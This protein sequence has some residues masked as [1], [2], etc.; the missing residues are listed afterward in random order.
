MAVVKHIAVIRFSAMGDVAMTVPVIKNFL[1]QHPD[2]EITMVSSAFLQPLFTGMERCHFHP[3]FL[4]GGHTGVKGMYKLYRELKALRKFDAVADLHGVLRSMILS[5]FFKLS[6]YKTATIDKGRPGKK[7]LT[8]KENKVMKQLPT[9]FERYASVFKQ[10]G[11]NC[12]L[13]HES[14]VYAKQ[15]IPQAAADFFTSGS[16]VIGIAPF[17]FHQE[18]MYPLEK[19]KVVVKTLCQHYTILLFGGGPQEAVILQAWQDEFQGKVFNAAGK[20]TF[21]EELAVISNCQK[22]ISM[23][24]ANMHLASLYGVPVISIW[25]A[26]HPFAGFY[27]WGQ[28]L[29]NIVSLEL[30]CR[31]C[32][33]FGNKP[34]WRGDH[35]CMKGI[36]E[37]TVI[38]KVLG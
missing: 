11:F 14:P 31:P 17:A 10:L 36:E 9:S 4:K 23:D 22:M 35:A 7:L 8:Q 30:F 13:K 6:G 29:E 16:P 32:S 26:T 24:S 34:C 15:P 19:M 20:F 27:G 1:Q 12:I 25:G 18:K 33:V 21:A 37:S 38:E 2:A 3:A 28:A 5:S